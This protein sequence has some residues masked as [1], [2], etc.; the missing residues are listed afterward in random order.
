M[1]AQD[2]TASSPVFLTAWSFYASLSKVDVLKF[3]YVPKLQQFVNPS[4][5]RTLQEVF[6][7]LTHY[8]V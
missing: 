7:R 1:T 3:Q 4:T 5:E 2:L 8:R 6:N